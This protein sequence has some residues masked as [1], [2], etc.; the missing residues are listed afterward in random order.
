MNTPAAGKV[1]RF[2]NR[3]ANLVELARLQRWLAL[4]VILMVIGH[5]GLFGMEMISSLAPMRYGTLVNNS[6]I[7]L[8]FV[9]GF[10]AA[11]FSILMGSVSGQDSITIGLIALVV[12]IVPF[13]SFLALLM[14]NQRVVGLFNGYGIH[15]G[16]YGASRQDLNKLYV[17]YCSH[18]GYEVRGLPPGPCPEC[19]VPFAPLPA[20]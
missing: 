19:G 6:L 17:G 15:I 20:V 7:G 5:A 2:G 12:A 3:S 4:V 1:V 13:C 11:I 14:V 8:Y 16:L 10:A 18:C 9:I